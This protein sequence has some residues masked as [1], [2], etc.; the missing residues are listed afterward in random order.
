MGEKNEKMG[1]QSFRPAWRSFYW[2]MAGIV[3]C[4][5]AVV[6]GVIASV[7]WKEITGASL[8]AAAC[9]GVHMAFKRFSVML[10]VK[11]EEISLEQ[12]FI[13]RH[14]VEIS[15]PNIRT[16]EVRQSVMQRILDVGNILVGS[17]ATK[18]YEICVENMPKPYALRDMIQTYERSANVR[19]TTTD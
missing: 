18:D 15:T 14:S 16:I 8:I 9:I 7:Y 1:A 6:L 19:E 11:P 12:G 10:V 13:G 4:F 3:L 17:A 5:A 2:H